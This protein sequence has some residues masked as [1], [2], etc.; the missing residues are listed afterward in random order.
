MPV[1]PITRAAVVKNL[2]PRILILANL[3][4]EAQVIEAELVRVS[5]GYQCRRVWTRAD[6][7]A[8]LVDFA[9]EVIVAADLGPEFTAMHALRAVRER[10]LVIPF[11]LVT[12]PTM[13]RS[14]LDC[15]RE[16]ADDYVLKQSLARLPDAIHNAIAKKLA[17]TETKLAEQVLRRSED[18]YRV[19]IEDTL[20]KREGELLRALEALQESHQ[21]LQAAQ[22]RLIQMAK[23]ESIGRLAAGVAHEVKNPLTVIVMGVEYLRKHLPAAAR[24]GG[25]DGG[26]RR[27]RHRYRPRGDT[28]RAAGHR[29]RERSRHGGPGSGGRSHPPQ[30]RPA[31]LGHRANRGSGHDAERCD[32]VRGHHR[33]AGRRVGL[34][35]RGWLLRS[36][37]R[38]TAGGLAFPADLDNSVSIEP[39]FLFVFD[40]GTAI[41]SA[42][43]GVVSDALRQKF[44][45][46]QVALA[47][48]APVAVQ[49]AG[50][51]W[52]VAGRYSVTRD[53]DV[54]A[55]DDED[56]LQLRASRFLSQAERDLLTASSADPAFAAATTSL[57]QLQDQLQGQVSY[58]PAVLDGQ[59]KARLRFTGPMTAARK[60]CLDAVPADAAYRAAL[61]E[62]YD[63]PR[64]F[65]ARYARSFS[66]HEF[67]ADL[68]AMPA[69]IIPDELKTRVYFDGTGLRFI[70][71]MTG[72]QRDTL[73]ALSADISYHTAV[74]SLYDQAEPAAAGAW[75]PDAEEEFLTAPDPVGAADPSS[76]TTRLFDTA[77]TPA[78]RF[79]LV[80]A[81]VL[82]YLRRTLSE[83]L[84]AQKLADSLGL[85]AKTARD[86]LTTWAR[87]PKHPTQ[88]AITEFLAAGFAESN[89]NVPVTAAAFPGQFAAYLLLHKISL[90]IGRLG[91]TTAQLAPVFL[92]GPADLNAF[93]VDPLTAAD[94]SAALF[95]GWERLVNLFEVRRA[96]PFGETGLFE[97][98]DLALQ[99]NGA[100]RNAAK[101]AWIERLAGY[102]QWPLADL[103]VLLGDR[104]DAHV[105][106]TLDTAFP[107]GY[108]DE[109]L[110]LR[111]RECF[112]QMKRLGASAGQAS[113]WGQASPTAAEEAASAVS[114]KSA[115]KAKYTDAQWLEVAKPLKDPLRVKQRDALVA[116]LITHPDP[117][118]G[119]RWRDADELYAHFLVDVQMEP[120]MTST[121]ILQA[122]NSAQLYIQRCLMN[123]EPGVFLTPDDVQEWTRWRKQYR[124]WEANRKV[125]F[126]PENWIEPELRDDKS[127]FFEELESELQQNDLTQETAEDAFLHYLEKLDS[128]GRLEIAGLYHQQEPADPARKLEP[129]DIVHVFGRTYAVPHVHFY[130]RLEKGVWSPWETGGA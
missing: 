63:A 126:Y 22:H 110:V 118:T 123:L 35:E 59:P 58:E 5:F 45:D 102:T 100:A 53:G 21:A 41:E 8:A 86:L 34:A 87:A 25:L 85:E 75:V 66:V 16:G 54:F 52:T 7:Q 94:S 9:P 23:M 130:R 50:V 91:V 61:Q 74:R 117:A 60:A 129:V 111:L 46:H 93:P 98:F 90:V 81:K 28:E 128:V 17:E 4:E 83:R 76:D 47:A 70:G 64:A 89:G 30:A 24:S 69:V 103:E 14:A 36:G 26:A 27:A 71:V 79:L 78:S 18:N 13:E 44:G 48:D 20:E 43:G 65:I 107:D 40:S 11:I 51:S 31:Q 88:K 38:V 82:P 116:Y 56:A 32:D 109:R 95:A 106:G 99:S 127:P 49:A 113:T 104:T 42:A 29:R 120:C 15:M 105:T 108:A 114:I 57:F 68:P 101:Q 10:H 77:A 115:A 119:T 33:S 62:L 122:T 80:L 112:R 39:K 37:D 19:I 121:R 72:Q 1:I 125:L 3:A 6:F 12:G 84:V 97:L 73:L 96:L 124:L 92:T 55:V 2:V 67:S